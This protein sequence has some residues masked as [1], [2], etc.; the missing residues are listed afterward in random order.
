MFLIFI[1]ILPDTDIKL[2]VLNSFRSQS[3][4]LKCFSCRAPDGHHAE[5]LID[6]KTVGSITYNMVTRKCT[7]I[8]EECFPDKCSCNLSGNKFTHIF[9]FIDVNKTTKFSC[10]M[11]FVDNDKSSIFSKISTVLFDKQGEELYLQ[12]LFIYS[13]NDSH[14]IGICYLSK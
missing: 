2:S 7:H 3:V 9:P 13:F 12:E 6:N 5:F 10:R 1:G 11:N 4:I 8:K 14:R